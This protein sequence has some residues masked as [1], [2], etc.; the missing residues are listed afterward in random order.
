MT[1]CSLHFDKY[2]KKHQFIAYIYS[3]F[4]QNPDEKS[5]IR[6]KIETI[7]HLQTV[8]LVPMSESESELFTGDMSKDNHSPGPVIRGAI[9]PSP[10]KRSKLSNR[11]LCILRSRD[12]GTCQGVPFSCSLGEET[13]LA[14]ISPSQWGL[15]CQGM[16][17]PG[18]PDWGNKVICGYTGCTF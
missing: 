6:A 12:K 4:N 18:M 10:Y 11:I 7:K 3:G 17:I 5:Y 14:N 9:V 16:M 8:F 13:G 15:K 2:K 1:Q